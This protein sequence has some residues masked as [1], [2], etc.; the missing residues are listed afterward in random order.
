VLKTSLADVSALAQRIIN[1]DD[2]DKQ[3]SLLEKLNA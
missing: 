3:R 2:P 1:T